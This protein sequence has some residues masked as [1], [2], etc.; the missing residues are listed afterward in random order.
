[1]Y[2]DAQIKISCFVRTFISIENFIAVGMKNII[3]SNFKAAFYQKNIV[4]ETRFY[5]LFFIYIS[6]G[7]EKRNE[8]FDTTGFKRFSLECS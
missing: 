7:D 4:F 1:M 8:I 2:D 6:L 5:R 3:Y